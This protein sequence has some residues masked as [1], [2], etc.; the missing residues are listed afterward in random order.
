MSRTTY[1]IYNI[2]NYLLQNATVV[3]ALTFSQPIQ[4][5]KDKGAGDIV[6]NKT[7]NNRKRGK[8][9]QG[10]NMHGVFCKMS[11]RDCRRECNSN[12]KKKFDTYKWSQYKTV[13]KLLLTVR[14][15]VW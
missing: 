1:F 8:E 11:K 14:F 7:G 15:C 4:K 9:R 3:Y 6:V 13:H 10:Q 12:M 2:Y 5:G